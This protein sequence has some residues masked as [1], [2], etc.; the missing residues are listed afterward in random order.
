[1]KLC[2]WCGEPMNG[3]RRKRLT[4]S[5]RCRKALNRQANRDRSS[6]STQARS[7]TPGSVPY[8]EPPRSAETGSYAAWL[9][10]ERFRAQLA[11]HDVMSQPLT[12]DERELLRLQRAN[13][14]VLLEPLRQRQLDRAIEQ[15]RREAEI[16][17]ERQPLKPEN[18]LDPSSLGSLGRRAAQSRRLNRPVDPHLSILRPGHQSGPHP[19]D[20]EP[21]CI[22][23]PVGRNTVPWRRG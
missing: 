10:D 12:D 15:Q 18:P 9:A 1:M 22:D 7:V 21:Q 5:N 14:G 8:L 13:P 19:W 2:A 20:D 23:W 6:S 17:Q 16:Y 3:T 11:D 4:C